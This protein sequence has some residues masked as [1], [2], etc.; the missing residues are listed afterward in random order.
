MRR[1]PATGSSSWARLVAGWIFSG[2][3]I[4]FFPGCAATRQQQTDS[5]PSRHAVRSHQVLLLSDQKVPGEEEVLAELGQVRARITDELGVPP[6]EREVVVYLF[7]DRD[8]Y[9]SYMRATHPNLPARRAFFIGT[10]KELAVYAHW[11][12]HILVDLRH[13]YTHGLLHAAVGHVPLWIDEGIAEYMEVGSD[14]IG[15]V[16][17]EHLGRLAQTAS[18]GWRPDLKRLE[19][20]EEVGEMSREDYHE[21]WAWVHYLLHQAPGGQQLLSEYLVELRRGQ[22]PTPISARL[23]NDLAAVEGQ[24]ARYVVQLGAGDHVVPATFRLQSAESPE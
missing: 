8:R 12:D 13:E 6:G 1:R 4:L 10:P 23:G 16:N 9:A 11:G 15:N 19:R 24:V 17:R 7:S 3:A 22:S 2:A 14:E 5:L 18:Q 21:A 20:L